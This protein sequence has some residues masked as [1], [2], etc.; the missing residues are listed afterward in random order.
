MYWLLLPLDTNAERHLVHE[1]RPSDSFWSRFLSAA[2]GK[3]LHALD[4]KNR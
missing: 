4:S 1:A 2:W 3:L